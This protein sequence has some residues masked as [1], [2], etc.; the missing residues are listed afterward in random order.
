MTQNFEKQIT[1]TSMIES[2]KQVQDCKIDDNPL[3]LLAIVMENAKQEKGNQKKQEKE[4]PEKKKQEKQEKEYQ[5]KQNLS[6][7]RGDHTTEELPG[8]SDSAFN[9]RVADALS[10]R[11]AERTFS[12]LADFDS[13]HGFTFSDVE[14]MHRLVATKK[15]PEADDYIKVSS[16]LICTA[17]LAAGAPESGSLHL[18]K[19]QFRRFLKDQILNL[20]P[21]ADGP[22]VSEQIPIFF[23]VDGRRKEVPATLTLSE[24][25]TGDVILPLASNAPGKLPN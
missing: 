10:A 6:G 5:E 25:S 23:I 4:Y 21:A 2:Q 8:E 3:S 12:Q 20:E 24:D 15:N 18:T 9:L 14:R 7:A 11:M 22:A 19:D 1:E 13:G 17:Q 16:D